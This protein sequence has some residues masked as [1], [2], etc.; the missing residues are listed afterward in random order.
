[1]GRRLRFLFGILVL[2]LVGG[3]GVWAFIL[4]DGAGEAAA[5]PTMS[6]SPVNQ[7]P[8]TDQELLALQ[9]AISSG[10]SKAI[11]SI[12][13]EPSGEAVDPGTLEKLKAMD[14]KLDTSTLH[15]LD[16]GPGWEMVA[17]DTTGLSWR[18]GFLRD[19]SGH[20]VVVYEE[21]VR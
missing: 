16:N 5:T 18:V 15:Q 1:M 20:L 12:L 19:S 9:R 3:I 17:R 2:V 11:L 7:S 6:S 4:R 8:P 21:P 14:I 13:G 10:D